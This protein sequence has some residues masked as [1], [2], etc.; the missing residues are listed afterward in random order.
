MQEPIDCSYGHSRR[1]FQGFNSSLCGGFLSLF[2]T[3]ISSG[4]GVLIIE[5]LFFLTASNLLVV[6]ELFY[7]WLKG[8]L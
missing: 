3:C 6:V 4:Y 5:F 7:I 8:Q 1:I 2:W